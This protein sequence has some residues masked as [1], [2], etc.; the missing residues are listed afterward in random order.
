MLPQNPAVGFVQAKQALAAGN[1]AARPWACRIGRALG[2][3]AVHHIDAAFG[4]GWTGVTAANRDAPA[5]LQTVR[6]KFFNDA[7]FAPLSR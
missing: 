4:H 7:A 6:G 2:E 3:L 5:E 1:F